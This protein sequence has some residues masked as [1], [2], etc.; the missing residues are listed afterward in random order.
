MKIVMSRGDVVTRTFTIKNSDRTVF[1][2]APD[3][4]YLTVKST[5]NEYDFKFQKR[6]SEGDFILIEP[7]KYQ[8]TI[9]PEDTNDLKFMTYDFDIEI[10]KSPHLKKTFLGT[11]TIEKEVTHWYNEG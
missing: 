1:T 5:A 9:N 2:E 11:L 10:V 4:I 7:G 6:L 3:E 8:F